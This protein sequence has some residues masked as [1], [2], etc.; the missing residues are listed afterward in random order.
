MNQILPHCSIVRYCSILLCCLFIS[1]NGF[2]VKPVHHPTTHMECPSTEDLANTSIKD[3][4]K[5][6][7]K[8][9]TLKEKLLMKI[10]QRKM[11]KQTRRDLSELL[12]FRGINALSEQSPNR[13]HLRLSLVNASS[14]SPTLTCSDFCTLLPPSLVVQKQ[15]QPSGGHEREARTVVD[16]VAVVVL[17]L[18]L[19]VAARRNS[20][21]SCKSDL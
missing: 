19:C 14:L 4:E 6:S 15:N 21:T 13:P 12:C 7:N 9:Y 16:R 11:K 1:N 17:Q 2:A 5:I 20:P 3:L 8:K 10:L 18:E